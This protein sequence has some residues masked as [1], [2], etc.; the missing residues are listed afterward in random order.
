MQAKRSVAV[1]L[2]ISI[3][4]TGICLSGVL[5]YVNN[6]CAEAEEDLRLTQPHGEAKASYSNEKVT[7]NYTS[8]D[9]ITKKHTKNISIRIIQSNGTR[10]TTWSEYGKYPVKPGDAVILPVE[11]SQAE[12]DDTYKINVT[13]FGYNAAVPE[14]CDRELLS[15]QLL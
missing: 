2:V 10:R 14:H 8:G 15:S 11:S 12:V 4:L 3:A 1:L 13:W 5:P 7:I 6:E 9:T